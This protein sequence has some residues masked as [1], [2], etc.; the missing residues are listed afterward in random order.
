MFP[1]SPSSPQHLLLPNS[2]FNTNI[3]NGLV[4]TKFA[5]YF[6]L[7][8]NFRVHTTCL[9]TLASKEL[10]KTIKNCTNRGWVTKLWKYRLNS[11]EICHVTRTVIERT[12]FES[13]QH[14]LWPVTCRT[15]SSVRQPGFVTVTH[16]KF[17]SKISGTDWIWT[18]LPPIIMK[19]GE[20]KWGIFFVA[21]THSSTISRQFEWLVTWKI[22]STNQPH[23]LWHVVNR[24]QQKFKFLSEYGHFSHLGKLQWIFGDCCAWVWCRCCRCGV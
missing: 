21:S 7:I 11:W 3:Y 19:L 1:L 9:Q 4:E 23:E 8:Y 13:I 17:S 2:S 10:L 12:Q 22:N 14:P 15:D 6:G 18:E 24:S 20:I 16:L 5:N